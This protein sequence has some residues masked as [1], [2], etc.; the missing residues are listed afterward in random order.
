[1]LVVLTIALATISNLFLVASST[2]SATLGHPDVTQPV[3]VEEAVAWLGQH[4]APDDVILSSYRVGNIIPARIGRRV[5]WGHWD[6]TAF[7][8][9]KEAD[10]FAF[11]D[12]T[13]TDAERQAI[14]R[15]YGVDYVFY[16]PAEQ[17]LGD[18]NP[19]SAPYLVPSFSARAV[20]VYRVA[21]KGS[22]Q[23]SLDVQSNSTAA[24][25]HRST[26]K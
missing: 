3:A 8:E 14:L 16:G 20:T 13:S 10:V 25:W 11:F 23:T 7:F 1:M 17:K 5:V 26:G 22:D 4:S 24:M 9:E 6:E 21:G 15:G 12:G 18:F 19:T 2:L